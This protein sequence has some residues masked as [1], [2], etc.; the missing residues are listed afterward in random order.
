MTI[1]FYVTYKCKFKWWLKC[2]LNSPASS[3][4]T[5]PPTLPTFT[6]VILPLTWSHGFLTLLDH[7]MCFPI[8]ISLSLMLFLELFYFMNLDSFF[9]AQIKNFPSGMSFMVS[10]RHNSSLP[11]WDARIFCT[12]LY[13]ISHIVLFLVLYI[14]VPPQECE[15]TIS[16]FYLSWTYSKCSVMFIK[17]N[18][19]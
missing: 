12:H 7:A 9:K 13:Y 11:H 5:P 6:T 2:V 18:W 14:S 8:L 4:I 16:C 19:T 15:R 1:H 10:L 3:P 17:L